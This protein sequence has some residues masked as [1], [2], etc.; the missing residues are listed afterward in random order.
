MWITRCVKLFSDLIIAHGTRSSTLSP[1]RGP[2]ARVLSHPSWV[3]YFK[4][5]SIKMYSMVRNCINIIPVA[6]KEVL[7]GCRSHELIHTFERAALTHFDTCT[8]PRVCHHGRG[9]KCTSTTLQSPVFPAT[10]PQVATSGIFSNLFIY[11]FIT[12]L[13]PYQDGYCW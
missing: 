9:S 13:S 11:D 8:F 12:F 4:R 1:L 7:L 6:F 3:N 10:Y 5:L 2:S